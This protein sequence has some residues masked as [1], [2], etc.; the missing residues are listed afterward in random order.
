MT[1]RELLDHYDEATLWPAGSGL[2]LPL[3][4][5]QALA[6]RDLRIARGEKPRGFKVGFTNRGI[7]PRYNVFAP[8][9][10]TVWNTT[11]SFCEAQGEVSLA[12]MCQPRL[13]PEAVFGMAA[14][15]PA[16]ASLDQL[17]ACVEWIAPGF[18]IVQTHQPGWKF[19]APDTVAD[20]GLHGRLLVGR[21][22]PVAQVAADAGVFDQRL[23]GCRLTLHRGDEQ[24]DEGRGAN[25]LDGPLHA[26]R[27]FLDALREC[28]G[29][30]DLQ[31]GDVVTTGTWTDAWPVAPGERWAARFEAP[32]S[33]LEVRFT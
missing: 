6:V 18:E 19:Q 1:P 27:Y 16:G 12:G 28:P 29:A 7:W 31:P 8:I 33:T 24:V 30:P 13:E 11:L 4:Y 9:W 2:D 23:A 21:R 17:R 3:A 15:P 25:V 32:L 22:V 20:G 10:G 14:T 26:L 5:Q